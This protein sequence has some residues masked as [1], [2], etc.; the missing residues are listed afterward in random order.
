MTHVAKFG[1]LRYEQASDIKYTA[2]SGSLLLES[3]YS[4]DLDYCRFFLKI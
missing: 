2:S 3:V 1:I 4:T